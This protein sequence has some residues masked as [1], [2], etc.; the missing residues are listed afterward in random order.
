[1]KISA[2]K[3]ATFRICTTKDPW[4]LKDLLLIT[5]CGDKIPNV[6]A[7]ITVKYLGGTISPWRGHI[8]KDLE[9]VFRTTLERVGRLALTPH[10]KVQLISTYIIPH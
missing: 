3:C 5:K 8:T 10:Q 2:P 7:D 6:T 9:E 1:M 4:H